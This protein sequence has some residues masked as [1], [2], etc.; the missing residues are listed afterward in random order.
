MFF[1][2]KKQAQLTEALKA[3]ATANKEEYWAIVW[4]RFRK[5]RPA[6]WSWRILIFL[7]FIALF[8]DFIANEKPLYCKVAG[9]HHFPVLKD[10]SVSLGW[11]GWDAEFLNVDW[12]E[13]EYE[14]VWWPF[15]TYSA[16]TLDFSNALFKGPFDQQT[17]TDG[18]FWHRLG[19]DEIGRDVA[20]GMVAGTRT[21]ML[22]GLVAMSV[23]S[24]I[25][26]LLGMFAGYF[27]DNRWRWTRTRVVL[28]IL[29]L[30]AAW[31]YAFHVRSYILF[32][33]ESLWWEWGK[34]FLLSFLIITVANLLARGL[35]KIPALA[36]KRAI[37]IDLLI[38]RIIE[39]LESLPGLL[40]LL[41]ILAVIDNPGILEVMV[42]IG[43]LSWT[44]IARFVRAEMLRVRE[45]E[46]I[47]AAQAMG[48][49]EWRIIWRHAL[50]N[51][52]S[53]VLVVVAFGI[54]AA[55]LLEAVLTFIGVGLSI[56]QVTWGSLLNE[57]RKDFSAWWVALVPGFAIFITVTVFNLIG[58]GLASA[59][60][61]K[62]S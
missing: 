5:N 3:S 52:L 51:S 4:R 61:T 12:K 11:S 40:L 30:L 32:E 43:L 49:S 53:P 56:D 41:A 23:A 24:F 14:Q 29:A 59:M 1:G 33:S 36:E 44:G 50:P 7:G 46:Y 39:V 57:A 62:L 48:F 16:N 54:A 38:M 55:I 17:V 18:R 13:I 25:G 22:V 8:A 26:I 58:D 37:P 47:E 31:F 6:L 21:A 45:L 27:G 9:A 28:N 20:A 19:T 34:S 15:I 2:R 10:Y 42:I 35:E 60:D